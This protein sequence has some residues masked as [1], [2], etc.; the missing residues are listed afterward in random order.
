[1]RQRVCAARDFLPLRKVDC[2]TAGNVFDLSVLKAATLPQDGL[3]LAD[4]M[5]SPILKLQE[6]AAFAM[7]CR[8]VFSIVVSSNATVFLLFDLIQHVIIIIIIIIIITIVY[9]CILLLPSSWYSFAG[10]ESAGV[11][12]PTPKEIGAWRNICIYIYGHPPTPKIYLSH[13]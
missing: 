2:F 10:T 3:T 9:Y 1:M 5:P 13:F 4:F 12:L 11:W 7:A 6:F 8:L